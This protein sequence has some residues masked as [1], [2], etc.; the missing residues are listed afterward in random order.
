MES[1]TILVHRSL[2]AVFK[3]IYC[4]YGEVS[5]DA[6]TPNIVILV[7]PQ[8]TEPGDSALRADNRSPFHDGDLY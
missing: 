7:T 4:V 8:A 2:L 6:N 3:D 5:A 1:A